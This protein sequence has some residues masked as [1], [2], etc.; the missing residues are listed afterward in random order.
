MKKNA[1]AFALL[2]ALCMLLSSCGAGSGYTAPDYSHHKEKYSDEDMYTTVQADLSRLAEGEKAFAFEMEPADWR[3]RPYDPVK[4]EV[5]GR[6][7]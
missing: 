6:C 1:R 7:V 2:L 4:E 3:G 5:W